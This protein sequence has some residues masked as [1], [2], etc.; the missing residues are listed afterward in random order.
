MESITLALLTVSYVSLHEKLDSTCVVIVCLNRLRLLG[1]KIKVDSGVD[2]LLPEHQ[3][4]G[5]TPLSSHCLNS[6]LQK[7]QLAVSPKRFR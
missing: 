6:G 3:S 5:E 1:S 4:K 2:L 7:I